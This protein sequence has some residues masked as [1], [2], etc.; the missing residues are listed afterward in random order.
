MDITKLTIKETRENL[1]KGEYSEE[2]LVTEY[3]KRVDSLNKD[4]N[5]LLTINEKVDWKKDEP[6]SGMPSVFKDVYLTQ[7]LR[8][9]AG[10]NVLK[11]YIGQY[12]GTVVK[13]IKQ[14]GGYIIGKANQDAWAHGSSG[15]NSDFPP[16]KNPWNKDYVPGGSS[17]GSA[18]AVAA[19]FCQVGFGSDTGGSIRLPSTFCNVVGLK[20]TYGRVSRYGVIAMA[21]S[22]DSIGHMTKTVYD[23]ALILEQ[24]AGKDE[25]DATSSPNKPDEYTKDLNK[26]IKG[27]KIGIPKEYFQKGMD[28]EVEKKVKDVIKKIEELGAEIHEV[29]LPNTEYAMS[30]YYII[31]PA[32]VSSN[33]ARFDGIRYGNGRDAF[34]AEAKRRIMLGTYILSAGYYDAYYVKAAK[35]RT[36]LCRD[37]D[38]AF[39]KVDVLLAPVSPTPAFKLGQ[40]TEDPL[41]M[42]LSDVFTVPVNMTGVPSLAMPC[43]FINGLPIGFQIIGPQF[44]EKTLYQ[45]G[46]AY[47]QSTD[48][49]KQT[50]DLNK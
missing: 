18:A 42:Y 11:S 32:E 7:G 19:S 5:I 21:S 36:L 47:E 43:G 34:G 4:L 49:H 15:E 22:T 35:V 48:W 31:Q 13:K 2:E 45:V 12:D 44:S 37:F 16:T 23:N 46:Y 26:G 33:L 50:P 25:K 9:T 20:P 8:T 40:K 10:S 1:K 17:S 14:K 24:T 38:D 30:V 3:K 39:K 28:T 41:S 27:L 29:S 6:L